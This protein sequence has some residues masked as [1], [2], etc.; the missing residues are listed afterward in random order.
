MAVFY[1][2]ER[3]KLG[4]LTGS[5]INWSDQLSS[6][7]PD[8]PNTLRDLPAGYLRCDG[9]VYQAEVYPQ[10]AEVLGVGTSCRY[11]KPDTDLLD[12]MLYSSLLLARLPHHPV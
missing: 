3:G 6:T 10:L 8:D 2:K 7:D 12:N 11:K 4:T 5:I 9:S 1:S